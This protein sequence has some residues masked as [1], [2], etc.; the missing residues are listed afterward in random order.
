MRNHLDGLAQ[1]FT[2]PF[3]LDH[4]HVDLAG[5]VV[6]IPG[7]RTIGESFVM[8]KVQV[9][10]TS[11]IQHVNLAMLVGTHGAWIH[12]DVG[13]QFLHLD[14][15][16]TPF[17]QHTDRGTGESFPQGANNSACHK[18]MFCHTLSQL[19]SFL[20]DIHGHTVPS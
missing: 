14:F 10:L 17:K 13:I 3:L 1:E 6:G 7:Q 2:L 8:T 18:N 19:D 12:V 9:G 15:Q 4:R 11:V 5:G 16:A 20:P